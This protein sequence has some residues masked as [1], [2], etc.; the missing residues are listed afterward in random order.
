[1]IFKS[2]EIE[3]INLVNKKY[4][5]FYGENQGYK[6]QIIEEKFKKNYKENVFFYEEN[7][8]LNN[9]EVFFNSILSRSFFD[10]KKLIIINRVTDKIK[11]IIDE[12]IEKK[13]EDLVLI[14]NAN[15]LEKK[16]KIRL[17]YE[18]GKEQFCVPFYD[19]KTETLSAITNSFFR[20]NKYYRRGTLFW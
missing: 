3:K 9:E 2:F 4:F 12:I 18:K 6:N 1:M 5:L 14:L 8:I 15:A 19:D 11:P 17:L 10:N 16:S 13:I 20:E 7:E